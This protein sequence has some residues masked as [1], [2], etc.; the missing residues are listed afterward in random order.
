MSCKKVFHESASQ[1]GP[2]LIL[3]G[4]E[5]SCQEFDCERDIR[6]Y[7]LAESF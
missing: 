4:K 3:T 5:I 1:N 2:I 7:F 6:G